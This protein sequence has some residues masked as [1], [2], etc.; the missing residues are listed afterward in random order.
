M[1]SLFEEA[2]YISDD[3]LVQLFCNAADAHFDSAVLSPNET[4][5]YSPLMLAFETI[6]KQSKIISISNEEKEEKEERLLS[7]KNILLLLKNNI[8]DETVTQ[9][10]QVF[11][12]P[13]KDVNIACTLLLQPPSDKK[14]TASQSIKKAFPIPLFFDKKNQK[15]QQNHKIYCAM[16]IVIILIYSCLPIIIF[17]L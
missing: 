5:G 17:Y 10:S 15:H 16:M 2:I 12:N 6:A 11:S 8:D 1:Y 14:R 3:A 13:T 7:A 9:H 4:T